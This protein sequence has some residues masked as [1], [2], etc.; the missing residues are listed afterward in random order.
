MA[1]PLAR[2]DVGE[3]MGVPEVVRHA[4]RL[5]ALIAGRLTARMTPPAEAVSEVAKPRRGGAWLGPR[6]R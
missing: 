5:A 2:G 1:G 6:T 4:E 3:L